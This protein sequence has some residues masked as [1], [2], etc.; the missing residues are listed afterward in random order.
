MCS[1]VMQQQRIL[2][3]PIWMLWSHS[4]RKSSRWQRLAH[5]EE[6][7]PNQAR[8]NGPERPWLILNAKKCTK[9]P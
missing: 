8:A 3:F 9:A 4:Q 2:D 1:R 6:R 7:E 5:D